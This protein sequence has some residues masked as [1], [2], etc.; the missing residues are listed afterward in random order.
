MAVSIRATEQFGYRTDR[1]APTGLQNISAAPTLRAPSTTQSNTSN[2][3]A[4]SSRSSSP[5]SIN[6]RDSTYNDQIAAINKALQEYESGAIG[7]AERYGTDYMTGLQRL[8]YTPGAGFVAM[9]NIIEA[10]NAAGAAD[11]T[12]GAAD[13]EMPQDLIAPV[14]GAFDI[15]G[16]ESPYSTAAQGVRA[17]RDEFAARGGLQSTD[18]ARK[19]NEFRN[20]LDEQLRG[21]ETGRSRFAEDLYR[22]VGGERQAAEERRN[23]ARRDAMQRAA[24]Q[25]ASTVGA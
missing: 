23:Q 3:G 17:L 10:L 5:A 2:V 8:G 25:A 1:P 13:A 20:Q 11:T 18:F 16:I 24:L 22:R 7:S 6:W 9:P 19:F 4:S 21:M 15:E 14:E 12:A